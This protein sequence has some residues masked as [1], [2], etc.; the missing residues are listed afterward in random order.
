MI[1]IV[2]DLYN[3]E[4]HEVYLIV[5]NWDFLSIWLLL[6]SSRQSSER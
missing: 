3:Q 2:T 1:L 6:S 5:A 4:I